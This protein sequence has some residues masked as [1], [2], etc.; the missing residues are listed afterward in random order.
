MRF[1]WKDKSQNGVQA[2]LRSGDIPIEKLV[3]ETDAPY[4]YPKINDKKLP[5]EVRNKITEPTKE[6]HKSAS[7]T[8][9]EPCALAA[10][11]ELIAAFAGRD[12]KEVSRITTENAKKIYGLA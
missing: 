6:L 2:G 1:L 4:M 9:N 3:I 10:V 11:C 5:S 8:R 7:F 12:P